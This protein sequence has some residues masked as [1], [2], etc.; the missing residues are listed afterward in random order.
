MYVIGVTR[1]VFE[2]QRER[3]TATF[4]QQGLSETDKPASDRLSRRHNDL[5]DSGSTRITST[6]D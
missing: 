1:D 2:L 6:A 4:G 5:V 3:R